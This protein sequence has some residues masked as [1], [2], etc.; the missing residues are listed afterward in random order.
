MRN[1]PRDL[2]TLVLTGAVAYALFGCANWQAKGREGVGDAFDTVKQVK[3][4]GILLLHE[5]CKRRA[6]ACSTDASKCGSFKSCQAA[7]HTAENIVIGINKALAAA[8]LAIQVGDQATF[9]TRLAE[10]Q[11]LLPK[12]QD[13]LSSEGVL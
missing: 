5:E 1:Q 2:L 13:V 12:L 4:V 10:A 8:L 3:N 11:A 6:T 7:R 9:A